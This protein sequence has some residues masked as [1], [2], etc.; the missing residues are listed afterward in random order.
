MGKF[1]YNTIDHSFQ[2]VC[3]RDVFYQISL[4]L[5]SL[6][7]ENQLSE[8]YNSCATYLPVSSI[9]INKLIEIVFEVFF[10]SPRH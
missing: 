6:K 4:A 7:H 9:A 8:F 1:T 3:I 2:F 5:L 10:K